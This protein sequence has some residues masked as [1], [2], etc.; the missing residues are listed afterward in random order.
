[1]LDKTAGFAMKVSVYWECKEPEN[2]I[3]EF[4]F[5][6]KAKTRRA[7]KYGNHKM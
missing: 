4:A 5:E 1:M 7:I 2:E 3:K 6:V